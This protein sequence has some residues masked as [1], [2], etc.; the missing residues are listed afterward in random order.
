MWTAVHGIALTGTLTTGTSQWPGGRWL[1]RWHD[2]VLQLLK[3]LKFLLL[4]RALVLPLRA[5][6]LVRRL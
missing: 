3:L 2:V 5:R 1:L 6:K 4:L